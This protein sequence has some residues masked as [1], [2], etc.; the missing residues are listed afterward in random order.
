MI[1]RR[2][3]MRAAGLAAAGCLLPGA[4]TRV[5]GAPARPVAPPA[6]WTPVRVRGVV[7]VGGVGRA[8]VAVTDGLTVAATGADGAFELITTSR[9]PHVYLSLPADADFG[10]PVGGPV[11]FHQRLHPNAAGEAA[12]AFELAPAGVNSERHAFFLLADPQ[13]QTPAEVRLFQTETVTD[14][15][16][17]A[18]RLGGQPLFG[19]SA[20]DLVYDH[21][22][23]LAGY[24]AAVTATG[25]PF[26]Q[27]LGNHDVA[28]DARTDGRSAGP[29]L[30]A[31]GPAHYSFNRGAV[32][33]VVLDDIHWFGGYIGYLDQ[34]Q[35]EWLAGDLALVEPGRTVVV[36]VHIPP[37]NEQHVRHGREKPNLAEV[38]GNREALY[39]ILA[40]YRAYA[41]CGHMHECEYLRDGGVDI[42]I[43]GA[44]CGAWW[45]G[46]VCPDGTPRGY[47]VYEVR[48][49]ELTRRYQSVGQPPDH[50]L[51]VYPAGSDPE[52]PDEIV[53][54][55]WG[56]D[57]SWRIIAY[58]DGLRAGEMTRRT[59]CDPLAVELYMGDDRPAKHPWV[60]PTRTDHLFYFKP[61]A[62]SR[63]VVVEATDPWGRIYTASV[64]MNG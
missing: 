21:P 33:Y 28:P 47:T 48:G 64:P 42:H 2:D 29:F 12:A 11:R 52:A 4:A 45:T 46:P 5:L 35:L 53:A 56:A 50:Q 59:G 9:R 41:L 51:R 19:V 14:L 43:G 25:L 10:A 57:G 3:F 15:K 30:R 63:R 54:N 40:P 27:V 1:D 22:E 7:R 61:P 17:S 24:T 31:F 58:A 62:G 16:A 13:V 55:V 6:P 26:F 8:G 34:S 23:L 36:F 44:V 38:V 18:A 32:H 60:E 39:E 20:G 37:Y 49:V